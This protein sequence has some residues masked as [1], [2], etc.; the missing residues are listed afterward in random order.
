MTPDLSQ[1]PSSQT[2]GGQSSMTRGYHPWT[3]NHVKKVIFMPK[4]LKKW[5]YEFF[6]WSI[7]NLQHQHNVHWHHAVYQKHDGVQCFSAL[8][9][10]SLSF[11]WPGLWHFQFNSIQFNSIQFNSFSIKTTSTDL[12]THKMEEMQLKAKAWRMLH[13][14]YNKKQQQ[15]NKVNIKQRQAKKSNSNKHVQGMIHHWQLNY[16]WWFVLTVW[17]VKKQFSTPKVLLGYSWVKER[18]NFFLT[19]FNV[20]EHF[21]CF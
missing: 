9:A 14:L 18:Y 15:T 10:Q 21:I 7:L 6:E 13:H 3:R 12:K 17:K 11:I 4:I 5:K 19:W 20:F 16:I 1:M 2:P 8:P